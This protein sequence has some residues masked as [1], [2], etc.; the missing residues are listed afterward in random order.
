ML[1]QPFQIFRL[2]VIELPD[3]FCVRLAFSDHLPDPVGCSATLRLPG[4]RRLRFRAF[5]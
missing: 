2:L 1:A 5:G 4:F 3:R